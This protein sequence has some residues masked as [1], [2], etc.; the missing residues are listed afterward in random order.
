MEQPANTCFDQISVAKIIVLAVNECIA[1]GL[2][3]FKSFLSIIMYS[4]R[5]V[6]CFQYVALASACSD[7]YND[8]DEG[9]LERESPFIS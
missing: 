7:I 1:A 3:V 8:L 6:M 5:L 4:G 9:R 2:F